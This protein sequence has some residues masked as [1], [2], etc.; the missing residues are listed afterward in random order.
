MEC[1]NELFQQPIKI[2]VEKI[3]KIDNAGNVDVE[4]SW[5][6]TNQTH[7]DVDL[8]ELAFYVGETVNNLAKAK[9]KDS[10]GSLELSQE[11]Q[12]SMIKLKVFPRINTLHSLQKYKITLLYQFPSNVH[13][14]GNVWLFSKTISGMNTSSFA[15]LISNKIDVKIRVVLPKLKKRFWQSFHY[16]SAPLCRELKKKEKSSQHTD[17]TVLEWTSSL[18]SNDNYEVELIYEVKT[19][20]QLT[21]FL[22]VIGTTIIV[23]LINFFF[24]ILK[25]S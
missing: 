4:R 20:T 6:L 11:K 7:E 9:A 2:G 13:K 10:S 23:G 1:G 14:L 16:E 24:H 3:Y 8:S 17:N 19:N 25:G 18:F 12:G 21:N 5:I 15:N 22:I